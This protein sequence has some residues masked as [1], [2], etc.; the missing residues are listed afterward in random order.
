MASD[1]NG[2]V[3]DHFPVP[4]VQ[5]SPEDKAAPWDLQASGHDEL[6]STRSALEEWLEG[7]LE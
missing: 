5:T 4:S 3:Q 1:E 2:P 6:E 7:A